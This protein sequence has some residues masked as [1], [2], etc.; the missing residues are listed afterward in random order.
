MFRFM[1]KK[2]IQQCHNWYAVTWRLYSVVGLYTFQPS[3]GNCSLY[4][5][6]NRGYQRMV[7]DQFKDSLKIKLQN[8]DMCMTK[9]FTCSK[10]YVVNWLEHACIWRTNDWPGCGR[11]RKRMWPALPLCPSGFPR[12]YKQ[13][14]DFSCPDGGRTLVERFI[15]HCQKSQLSL[16]WRKTGLI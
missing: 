13:T 8:D 2:W 7:Q 3:T 15:I 5:K 16:K 4:R 10:Y 12:P 1:C 14:W 9:A 6:A 11:G